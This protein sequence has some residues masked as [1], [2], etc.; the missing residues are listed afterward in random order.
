MV[1]MN[2]DCELYGYCYDYTF[3]DNIP[4]GFLVLGFIVGLGLLLHLLTRKIHLTHY[5]QYG[6]K[7]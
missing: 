5:F 6:V 7:Q 2:E 1:A 3:I 4:D